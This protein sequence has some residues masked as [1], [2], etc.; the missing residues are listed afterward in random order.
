M[1]KGKIIERIN[2]DG[3][4]SWDVIVAY[5][6]NITGEWHHRWKT[7]DG[8]RKADTL[9]T[10]MLREVDKGDYQKPSK[11]TMETHLNEWLNGSVRS[12]V[13]Q[14]TYQL[15]EYIARKHLIP[16]LGAIPISKLRAQN[17]QSLYADKQS[18]GLSPRTIELLHITLHKSLDNAVK[19]GLL[20]HN[21]ID[22]VD[23]PKVERHE[24]KTMSEDDVN[25][26]LDEARKGDYYNLFFLYLFTGLR[27]NE[28]LALRWTDIDLLGAQLSVNRTMQFID[29][30]VTFKQP[31]T[32]ASRRQIALSPSTCV[33]LRLH[34]EAQD[35][36][37]QRF[38]MVPVS[39]SELVFCQWDGKPYSPDVVT[40]NW[41]KTVRRCGLDGIRL[42]DARHTHASLLLKQGV[43]PKVV[44]E[45]LGH[46]GI[47]ITMDLYSHVVPGMQKAAALG[48]DNAIK[49]KVSQSN[50]LDSH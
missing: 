46:A 33:T 24:I 27:R 3:S 10:K 7:T 36:I 29:N 19:T 34:R 45:R 44:S 5:K 6:D 20:V 50:S 43:H 26:F 32:A 39:D 22:A 1:A 16:V 37:R 4:H 48:F 13:G 23:R 30:N 8:S 42:H 11:M 17:I 14:R 35:K 28:A 2:K 49:S 47:A 40:R 12:T 9:K 41:I 38:G 31:K 21:P 15:Y 25:R 18:E